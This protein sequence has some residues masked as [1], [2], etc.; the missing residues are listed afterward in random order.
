MIE[1]RQQ[2]VIAAESHGRVPTSM[3]GMQTKTMKQWRAL[4]RLLLDV[5]LLVFNCGR[6]DFR[7]KHSVPLN[8]VAQTT[9]AV[10]SKSH[11][12]MVV[13][14][15][16]GMLDSI[17]ALVAMLGIV[18]LV[19]QL[20][21][22]PQ[23]VRERDDRTGQL[24]PV[25]LKQYTLWATCRTLLAHSCWRHFPTLSTRLPELLLGG[26]FRGVPMHST[27]FDEPSSALASG[28]TK[29]AA[30]LERR[31]RRFKATKE[32]LER[33]LHFARVERKLMM[34]RLLGWSPGE[35]VVFVNSKGLII[36]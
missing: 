18:R 23:W 28:N 20:L 29:Q 34:K 3:V 32:A 26:T 15:S 24:Q 36:E 6:C 1:V 35:D 33:L 10:G 17:T 31:A 13:D 8:L 27:A 30:I 5:R 9:L 21:Q 2:A 25:V 14:I 11:V 4:G 7:A 22:A 12:D 19:E 16:R